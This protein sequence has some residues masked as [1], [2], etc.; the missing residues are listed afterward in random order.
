M[1]YPP[2]RAGSEQARL[3]PPI[4]PKRPTLSQEPQESPAGRT[5]RKARRAPPA[6]AARERGVKLAQR[7]PC[8]GG[9]VARQASVPEVA[10]DPPT[11]NSSPFCAAV[12]IDRRGKPLAL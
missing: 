3:L 2:D 12:Q 8:C 6:A 11:G 7:D 5:A 4:T 10:G 9:S 1:R